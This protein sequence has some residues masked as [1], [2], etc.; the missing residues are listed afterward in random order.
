M[1][2]F[3]NPIVVSGYVFCNIFYCIMESFFHIRGHR[4]GWPNH[5][6]ISCTICAIVLSL[7]YWT[8]IIGIKAFAGTTMSFKFKVDNNYTPR[9]ELFQMV[10]KWILNQMLLNTCISSLDPLLLFVHIKCIA[11]FL[12]EYNKMIN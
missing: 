1:G 10:S 5:V 3:R 7:C 12:V 4:H 8:N 6:K 11:M 2:C 9:S